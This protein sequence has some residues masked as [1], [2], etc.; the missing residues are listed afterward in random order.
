MLS[1]I[2]LGI[3]V[4]D[5]IHYLSRYQAEYRVDGDRTGAMR[6]TL[7][8]TGRAIVFTSVVIAGGGWILVF[9][10]FRPNAHFGIL[11]GVTMVSAPLADLLIAPLCVR[12][13]KLDN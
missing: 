11:T 4:D 6:R 2:A 10:S 5:T 9:S 12:F 7:M 8:S 3:A 1:C 13:F